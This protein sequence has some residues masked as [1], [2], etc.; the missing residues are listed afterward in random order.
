MIETHKL[1]MFLTASL[2][3]A[4]TP[5]PGMLYVLSRTLAGGRREGILSSFG[6]FLGG[7]VHVVAAAAGLSVV[8]AT[9]A[10]AFSVVKFA[11]AGYL[12]YL[13]IRMIV[14]ARQDLQ[15]KTLP[16][17]ETPEP[18]SSS[19]FLQGVLT[20]VLNPKTAL[21]FLAFIPQFI[22]RQG[23]H[24]F[25]GFLVLGMISVTLNTAGDLL[26]V[27]LAAPLGRL[28]ARS[29]RAQLNQRRASGLVMI[30]LGAYVAAT[31]SR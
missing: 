31:D 30:A 16:T 5:G 15:F 27:V 6:T 22:S 20:E 25:A 26:A 9:S 29:V 21:F 8:L 28:F 12:I 18:P 11:G 10:V 14:W 2:V 13:G 7:M 4:A 3:L 17:V 23:G 24:A 19:P 1:A